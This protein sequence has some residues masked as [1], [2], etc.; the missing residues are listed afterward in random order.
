MCKDRCPHCSD[1]LAVVREYA[2]QVINDSD[3]GTYRACCRR[4]YSDTRAYMGLPNPH[5][6]DCAAMAALAKV[7]G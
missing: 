1:L 3:E 5:A 2:E 6:K 4:E 7:E